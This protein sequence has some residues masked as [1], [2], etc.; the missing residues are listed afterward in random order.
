MRYML[1]EIVCEWIL[2]SRAIYACNVVY[3]IYAEAMIVASVRQL[4]ARQIIH[5]FFHS[6]CTALRMCLLKCLL[7]NHS[8][9]S[10]RK[11]SFFLSFFFFLFLRV[12][13]WFYVRWT[14]CVYKNFSPKWMESSYPVGQPDADIARYSSVSRIFFAASI[15]ILMT[16]NESIKWFTSWKWH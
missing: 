8:F 2:N 10:V 3:A 15:S 12:S 13:M 11:N 14:M 6:E 5:I 9:Y 7:L 4:T 1:N 16:I